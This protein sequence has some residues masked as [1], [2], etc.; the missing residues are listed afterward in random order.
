MRDSGEGRR[1]AEACSLALSEIEGWLSKLGSSASAES[2]A[3]SVT[4][5]AS[6][7]DLLLVC[8]KLEAASSPGF[9]RAAD[10]PTQSP[11]TA[12]LQQ[13]PDLSG[14]EAERRERTALREDGEA[15]SADLDVLKRL[16][17][18]ATCVDFAHELGCWEA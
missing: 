14:S 3:S 6:A 15:I 9:S 13:P 12:Y 16:T 10:K 11:A 17:A 18:M 7:S 5:P 2:L 1:R 8:G 4:S